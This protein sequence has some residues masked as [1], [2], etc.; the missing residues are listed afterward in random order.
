MPY[1][2]RFRMWFVAEVD[3]LDREDTAIPLEQHGK[4]ERVTWRWRIPGTVKPG[5]PRKDA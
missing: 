4:I 1:K 2:V 3:L 5:R